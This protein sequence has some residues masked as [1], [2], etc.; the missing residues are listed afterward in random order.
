MKEPLVKYGAYH[1]LCPEYKEV[2]DRYKKAALRRGLKPNTIKGNAS[3]GACFL[4]SMQDQGLYSLSEID[5]CAAMSFFTDEYGNAALSSGYKKQVSEVFLEDLGKYGEDARRIQAY[6]P[7]IR[8][9]RKTIPYLQPEENESLHDVFSDGCSDGLS[10][11]GKAI[12]ALLFFTGLRPCDIASLTMDAIDWKADE[13]RVVQNKTDVPLVLPLTAVIG[14]AIYDYIT[15]GRPESND[16]HIFLGVNR[17]HDPISPGAFWHI[18]SKIYDAA[19]IRLAEGDRRGTHLFR[20]NAAT[21]FVG[22]GIPRPVA[23]AVLGH[24]DPSSLDHYTFA[25]IGQLREC[26]LSI[27]K[28]PVR[29]GV[30]DI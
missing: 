8:P 23:S 5:E 1:H 14:N 29:E 9:R 12:A 7:C 28:S 6:L 10:L 18:A 26:A 4:H 15:S 30:F 2:V 3:A 19:G 24:E 20:Y 22:S 11:R 25:D 27:E 21:T 13:I 17:P 16:S